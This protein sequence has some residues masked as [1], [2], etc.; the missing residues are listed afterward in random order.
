M[1]DWKPRIRRV[2]S[3]KRAVFYWDVNEPKARGFGTVPAVA[4]QRWTAAY[5]Y[6]AALNLKEHLK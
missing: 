3:P 6:C 1:N 4:W 5:Q 2:W